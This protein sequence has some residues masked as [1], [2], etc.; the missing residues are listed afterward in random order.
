MVIAYSTRTRSVGRATCQ[1][2]TTAALETRVAVPAA[3]ALGNNKNKWPPRSAATSRPRSRATT[4]TPRWLRRQQRFFTAY[5]NAKLHKRDE[6]VDDLFEDLR[7]GRVLKAFVEELSGT[8][9]AGRQPGTTVIQHVA[10]LTPTFAFIRSTTKIV[11][12]GPQDVA[13]GNP[14]LVLGLLWSLIVFFA[15]RDL[16]ASQTKDLKRTL[17]DWVQ[18]STRRAC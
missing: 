8:T 11:G 16:G 6:A 13:D 14:G 7:D 15:S 9:I 12:I 18:V 3:A 10:N 17:L 5:V 1:L 2:L 4:R